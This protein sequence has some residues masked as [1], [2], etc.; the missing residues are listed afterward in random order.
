M[1]FK[2]RIFNIIQIGN[3]TDKLSRLFDY[4]IAILIFLNL[5]TTFFATF[6]ES[7]PYKDT[8]NTIEY[9]TCSIFA[10]EYILR[11]WTADYL[12]PDK[13][14]IGSRFKFIFS[15]LGLIDLF[16]FLPCF[17]PVVFSSGAVAFRL[18]RVVRIFRLF[19]INAQYDAFNVI[20]DVIKEKR[21]QLFSSLLLILILM[22]ASSLGM[23]SMEHDAQPDIFENAFSGIWWSMS[24]LLTVGYGDIYPIT[25]LG[26]VLAIFIA[27]LGV[28]I[29]S[30]P[31]G[32]IS[33][34]FVEHY[35]KAH[36]KDEDDAK[37]GDSIHLSKIPEGHAYIGQKLSDIVLPPGFSPVAIM[38]AG[39]RITAM[40]A[41]IK[42]EDSIVIYCEK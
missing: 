1:K 22:M 23:Y 21:N 41:S 38:R 15:F 18:F 19:R 39:E 36:K 29:V 40:D 11:I 26:R 9:V 8:I 10:A 28:G 2:R 27:F 4:A 31:T 14:E 20:T 12:Y 16:A 35:S 5:F 7:V 33:A 37:S 34:G 25:I 24:T 30:I 17:L 13:G 6:E 32:I 3:K 42:P